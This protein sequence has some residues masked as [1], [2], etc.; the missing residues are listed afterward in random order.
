[1]CLLSLYQDFFFYRIFPSS[2]VHLPSRS[3]R[4]LGGVQGVVHV[5]MIDTDVNRGVQIKVR[6]VVVTT[7]KEFKI[8][9]K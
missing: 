6:S 4:L 2:S 3:V 8:M 7:A 9:C 1:M 5:P